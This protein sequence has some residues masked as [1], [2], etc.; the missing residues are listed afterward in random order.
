MATGPLRYRAI[1]NIL[2]LDSSDADR[3]NFV[4]GINQVLPQ[5]SLY[6]SNPAIQSAFTNVLSTLATYK[7]ALKTAAGSAQQA[8]S[9]ANA[10]QG[11]KK[12]NDKAI[13]FFRDLVENDAQSPD[14]IASAGLKPYLGKPPPPPLVPPDTID[15]KPGRKG[16]GVTT[17]SVREPSGVRRRYAAQISLDGTTWT[18]LAG[19]G[20]SRKLVG[21]S[22]GTAWVRFALVRG[23]S[24]SDWSSAVPITFP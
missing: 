2:M 22:G 3:D 5:S 18:A 10:A 14:D 15:L 13:V 12:A 9:D 23:Q 17:A 24:Q 1:L 20:K 7:T 6:K 19:G 21:K 4:N 16:S 8:R 11:A